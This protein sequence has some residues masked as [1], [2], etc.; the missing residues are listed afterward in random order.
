MQHI[1]KVNNIILR[2]YSSQMFVKL[3]SYNDELMLID[4]G[5]LMARNVELKLLLKSNNT[6]K[7]SNVTTNP[8]DSTRI[9]FGT[10]VFLT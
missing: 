7:V 8:S 9:I 3:A 1:F 10:P 6:I 5:V 4:Q 2:H